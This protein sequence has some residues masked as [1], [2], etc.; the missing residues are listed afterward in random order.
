MTEW[1]GFASGLIVGMV[2][3]AAW[4]VWAAIRMERKG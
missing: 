3:T 4:C 1:I 2:L